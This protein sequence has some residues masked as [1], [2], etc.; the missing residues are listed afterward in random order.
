MHIP[1][2][3]S[4]TLAR[5]VASELRDASNATAYA[6]AGPTVIQL[7]NLRDAHELSQLPIIRNHPA[8]RHALA[9]AEPELKK[10]SKGA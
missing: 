4:Q 8:V 2:R 7:A 3:L 5:A 6:E 1:D 9:Y 10:L